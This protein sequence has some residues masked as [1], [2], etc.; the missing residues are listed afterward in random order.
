MHD[1]DYD[2]G[3]RQQARAAWTREPAPAARSLSM[4]DRV[5]SMFPRLVCYVRD[6][7][8]GVLRIEDGRIIEVSRSTLYLR[9][10]FCGELSPGWGIEFKTRR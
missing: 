1:E 8:R 5:L 4:V 3:W 2:L 7:K 10:R 6:H 9:C